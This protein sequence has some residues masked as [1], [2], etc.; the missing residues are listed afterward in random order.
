MQDDI[1]EVNALKKK[2]SGL[3]AI[4]TVLFII[5]II[6]IYIVFLRKSTVFQDTFIASFL[7]HV[8][9]NIA[10]FN[11]L[12][13]FYIALFGG[14]FFIFVPMEAYYINAL[15][16]SNPFILF[17]VF[18]FGILISYSAD[19]LI[20]TKISKFAKKAVSP[21]KFYKIKSLLNKFGRVGIFAASAVPFLPSQQVSFILGVFRYNRAR[22]FVLTFLGQIVKYLGIMLFFSFFT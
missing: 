15:R 9:S 18:I 20:G 11:L 16:H 12:G 2:V 21:K 10:S 5:S 17:L 13:A 3:V 4:G 6:V 14:L 22:F 1:V 7:S 8:G 19:Y